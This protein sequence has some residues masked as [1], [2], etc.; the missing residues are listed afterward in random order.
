MNEIIQRDAATLAELIKKIGK[1]N[2][3]FNEIERPFYVHDVKEMDVFGTEHITEKRSCYVLPLMRECYISQVRNRRGKEAC[4]NAA[5]QAIEEIANFLTSPAAPYSLL[6]YGNPG[7]GKTTLLNSVYRVIYT[8][9][10]TERETNIK[11]QCA[12]KAQDLG[13]LAKE[14]KGR[15]EDLKKCR[16][17][18]VDDLGFYGEAESVNDFGTKIRPTE[19]ILAYRYD[20]NLTT[21]AT[22]NL[23][24]AEIKQR[25]GER[26]YSRMREQFR[27]MPICGQDM[28]LVR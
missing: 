24:D 27:M 16:I 17:L 9:Y 25:Y 26:I 18:F 19:D 5:T 22:S 21:Y 10:E 7:T 15:Y 14:E 12:V 11:F 28:R 6:L 2:K 4:D 23:N 8:L 13:R 20:R 3:S 1:V